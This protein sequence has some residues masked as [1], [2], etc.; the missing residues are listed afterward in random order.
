[1][2]SRTSI[3][4]DCSVEWEG[5]PSIYLVLDMDLGCALLRERGNPHARCIWA[6][7]T[8]LTRLTEDEAIARLKA[9]DRAEETRMT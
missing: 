7:C 8:Q 9:R 4:P 6:L 5:H 3:T 2:R 1:M